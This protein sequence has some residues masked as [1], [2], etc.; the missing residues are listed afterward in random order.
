MKEQTHM[1][2]NPVTSIKELEEKLIRNGAK[3]TN[4]LKG[5]TGIWIPKQKKTKD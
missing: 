2:S 4:F 1:Q 3:R 5:K